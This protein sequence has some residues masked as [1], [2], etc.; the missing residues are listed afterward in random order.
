MQFAG[1]QMSKSN[2]KQP[3][4]GLGGIGLKLIHYLHKPF[5]LY[6]QHRTAKLRSLI[7]HFA[8][9]ISHF[10]S[11]PSQN[12]PRYSYRSEGS[13]TEEICSQCSG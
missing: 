9:C 5:F 10:H 3:S 13:D 6:E 12:A 8:F 4:L 1:I 7:L 11:A 2:G